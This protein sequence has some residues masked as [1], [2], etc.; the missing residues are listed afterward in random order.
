MDASTSGGGL[1]PRGGR[2]GT[3]Y[4]QRRPSRTVDAATARFAEE[5]APSV[6]PSLPSLK[7]PLRG[8]GGESG[9]GDAGD[10][11]DGK[12]KGAKSWAGLAG[13]RGASVPPGASALLAARAAQQAGLAAHLR[14]PSMGGLLRRAEAEAGA[15]AGSIK[16]TAAQDALRGLIGGSTIADS[17][18]SQG[19]P[20]GV[21]LSP[22]SSQ[23]EPLLGELSVRDLFADVGVSG[24]AGSLRA[25]GAGSAVSADLFSDGGARALAV[26][27]AR[28]MR[29]GGQSIAASRTGTSPRRSGGGTAPRPALLASLEEFLTTELEFLG[30]DGAASSGAPMLP[31]VREARLAVYR[32]AW[33][34]LAVHFRTYGGVM[35]AIKAEYDATVMELAAA[36]A[37]V[38]PLQAALGTAAESARAARAAAGKAHAAESEALREVI[39]ELH[40]RIEGMN[41][42]EAAAR[43]EAL[44]QEMSLLRR[45]LVAE[46]RARIK[47]E[48][49]A[50]RLRHA[51]DM[52]MAAERAAAQAE[53]AR[54]AAFSRERAMLE[55]YRDMVHKRDLDKAHA[56]IS[57]LRAEKATALLGKRIPPKKF[58]IIVSLAEKLEEH[59]GADQE[60]IL[61]MI[62]A[63][64]ENVSKVAAHMS[65]DGVLYG[66]G[67]S[68]RALMMAL[69]TRN[70]DFLRKHLGEEQFEEAD[71][72]LKQGIDTGTLARLMQGHLSTNGHERESTDGAPPSLSQRRSTMRMSIFASV[73]QEHEQASGPKLDVMEREELRELLGGTAEAELLEMLRASKRGGGVV[74]LARLRKALLDPTKVG[75]DLR[76][77]SVPSVDGNAS[78]GDGGVGGEAAATAAAAEEPSGGASEATSAKVGEDTKAEGEIPETFDE[79]LAHLADH[80]REVRE[81][82]SNARQ[83]LGSAKR[84]L[85][86]LEL[87]ASAAAPKVKEPNFNKEKFFAPAGVGASVPRYMRSKGK[88]RNRKLPKAAT[89]A[90]VKEVWRDKESSGNMDMPME[91]Y[92][93]LFLQKRFGI[94]SM[95]AEWGVN[96]V[97]ALQRYSYDADCELF[98]KVLQ[99]EIHQDVYVDQVAMLNEMQAHMRELDLKENGGKAL[100]RVLKKRFFKEIELLFSHKDEESLTQLRVSLEQDRPGEW[101]QYELLFEEDREGN[102]GS[103]AEELRDQHLSERQELIRQIDEA[104]TAVAGEEEKV[105][106]AQAAKAL[107]TAVGDADDTT[108]AMYTR[109]GFGLAE[110]AALPGREATMGIAAFIRNL[111][112]GVL[113]KR[114]RKHAKLQ[115][116]AAAIAAI[117]V[118]RGASPRTNVSGAGSSRGSRRTQDAS[119]GTAVGSRGTASGS[120]GTPSGSRGTAMGSLAQAAQ[121]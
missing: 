10:V 58:D 79:L 29:G 87:A 2:R 16:A 44:E 86:A 117:G 106:A 27:P 23:N 74:S 37:R 59:S 26:W 105:T 115:S 49:E 112:K 102:Q 34:H 60:C 35:S 100:G 61:N 41:A 77:L 18:A 9:E 97:E 42:A 98:L 55:R 109:R 83:E 80:V 68:G 93:Y 20:T 84:E 85:T 113:Q 21:F 56:M 63:N 104:L 50:D 45:E 70:H 73:A 65:L 53:E 96:M 82:A 12:G 32:Q 108:I 110:D 72:A 101:V 52:R 13:D 118:Q 121:A 89:E 78:G 62:S 7:L 11:G 120:R 46:R 92:F 71:K 14:V 47:H 107:R 90:M 30:G 116:T 43:G 28:S 22:E 1:P 95:I 48:R 38:G 114:K 4:Y 19:S 111:K 57:R 66:K 40:E 88:V 94:Q 36:A 5:S 91:E 39:R 31:H 17:A 75:L 67:I 8:A 51:E 3:V 24:G 64:A 6:F 25:V 99:G 103:F 33:D 69:E 81:D 54:E 119:R 76:R 15:N